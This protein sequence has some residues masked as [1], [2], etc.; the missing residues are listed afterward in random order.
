MAS[1]LTLTL[2]TDIACTKVAKT[3]ADKD[4][5]ATYST[6]RGNAVFDYMPAGTYYVKETGA[7]KDFGA[8]QNPMQ[9]TVPRSGG[10]ATVEFTNVNKDFGSIAVQKVRTVSYTH[11]DVYKR[12]A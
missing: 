4:A 5:I 6:E 7:I 11:L 2:Y 10:T 8:K 9:V 1:A 12:Q 3:V